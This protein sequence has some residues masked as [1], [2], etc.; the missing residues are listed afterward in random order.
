MSTTIYEMY[1]SIPTKQTIDCNFVP[2]FLKSMHEEALFETYDYEGRDKLEDVERLKDDLIGVISEVLSQ[3]MVER[4]S[5]SATSMFTKTFTQRLNSVTGKVV[6]NLLGRH[7]TQS[8]F[9]NQQH[10]YDV[11]SA[12]KYKKSTLSEE[13]INKLKCYAN[14]VTDEQKPATALEVHVLTRSNL[15]DGKGICLSVVDNK[16]KILTE[17]T[18]PGT[19]PVAGTIKLVLTKTPQT[20]PAKRGIWSKLTQRVMGKD[21]PVSG[22]IDIIRPDGSREIVNSTNQNCLFHAVIQATTKDP[23]D[24]VQQKAIELRNKV[25]QEILAKPYKYV[26]AVKIQNM[27]NKTNSSNKFKIEAGIREGDQEK[28]E[29]F[30]KDMTPEDII[31]AY[32]LGKVAVYESLLDIHKPTPGVVEADHIPPKSC[33][34]K[35]IRNPEMVKSLKNNNKAAY[36][37]VMSMEKDQNG[38]KKLCMNTLYWDHRRALTSGN[39]SESRASRDLLTN[40]LAS[41]N[42]EK[43]LKQSF[44]LAHPECSERIRNSL[45]IKH[46]IE[47]KNSGLSG[48]ADCHKYYKDGF[49]KLVGEYNRKKQIDQNQTDRLMEWVKEERY[50]DTSPVE[51]KEIEGAIKDKAVN[52]RNTDHMRPNYQRREL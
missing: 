52:R 28:Y 36:D 45:G 50:L 34:N 43:V 5:G 3:T 11:K 40:T 4:F 51:Y 26:K 29:R 21:T 19:N 46:N 47:S 7:K 37:L 39:S 31:N 48:V 33:L 15:L 16:A 2:A 14:T 13:E 18:Y 35:L 27:F 23:N 9:V 22:H 17:E 8:F 1:S 44:I 38:K 30:T 41:G 6:G 10:N 24:V 20:S 12:T 42:M 25:S 49:D 32:H